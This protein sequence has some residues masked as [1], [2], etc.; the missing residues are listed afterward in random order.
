MTRITRGAVQARKRKGL[1][2]LRQGVA[3][4][5]V[6]RKLGVTRQTVGKWARPSKGAGGRPKRAAPVRPARTAANITA[7]LK[8]EAPEVARTLVEIAKGGDVRAATLVMKLVGDDL[9]GGENGEEGN[10]EADLREL[11][12]CLETLPSEIA[13]QIVALLAEADAGAEKQGGA[14]VEGAAR[15]RR[16]LPWRANGGASDEGKGAV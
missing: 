13:G 9:G 11:E 16:R 1:K 6:A 5:E 14:Q 8:E 4:S 10:G 3:A 12:R 15:G 2:L 7:M